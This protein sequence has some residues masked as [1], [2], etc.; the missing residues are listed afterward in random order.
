MNGYIPPMQIIVVELTLREN[1]ESIIE[2]LKKMEVSHI[3][4][5]TNSVSIG[6]EY[7]QNKNETLK[8]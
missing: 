6:I 7:Y 5:N 8:N 3:Q 2:M 1:L 4:L